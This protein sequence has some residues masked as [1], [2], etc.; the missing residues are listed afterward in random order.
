MMTEAMFFTKFCIIVGV[1]LAEGTLIDRLFR[2]RRVSFSA[3]VYFG[4]NKT[5]KNEIES[6]ISVSYLWDFV[7]MKK[8]ET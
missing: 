5:E 1:A 4:S 8:N 6:V 7:I 2:F 3:R